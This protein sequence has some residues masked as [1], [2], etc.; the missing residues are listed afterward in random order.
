MS[1]DADGGGGGEA[2]QVTD[3]DGRDGVAGQHDL[4]TKDD[5]I[6][7]SQRIE[8]EPDGPFHLHGSIPVRA[9]WTAMRIQACSNGSS[10]PEASSAW[11]SSEP[12]T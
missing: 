3:R 12:P 6:R 5:E 7:L 9:W 8:A 10:R 11:R 2:R 1:S 4:L